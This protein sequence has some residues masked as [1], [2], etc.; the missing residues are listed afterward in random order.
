MRHRVVGK[1][2]GRDTDH[3]KALRFN[4]TRSLIM[5]ERIKTTK[6]KAQFV[7]AHVEKLI[8]IAKRALATGDPNKGVHA[9]RIVGSRL[10]NDRELVQ[11]V[12]DTLAPRY[13]ERPG[14][15]TRLLKLG[16]RA[17]DAADMVFLEFVDRPTE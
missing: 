10:R 6:A 9:R 4:L 8:T 12:F 7:E 5:Q 16:P 14:G 15:Y 2:L 11:K 13:A 1:H 3:R 17:G